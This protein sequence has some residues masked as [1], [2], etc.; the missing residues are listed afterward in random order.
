MRSTKMSSNMNVVLIVLV[1][2]VLVLSI[3]LV[4]HQLPKQAI[5][6]FDNN[7]ISFEC[8]A[9]TDPETSEPVHTYDCKENLTYTCPGT[10]DPITSR[11]SQLECDNAYLKTHSVNLGNS[12]NNNLCNI[13]A[14]LDICVNNKL[15]K[16][17]TNMTRM[18]AL[19]SC[20]K[21]CPNLV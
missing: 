1:V 12:E 4:I 16:N 21:E 14:N 10:L 2:I 15:A 20:S 3:V 9:P 17:P 8:P 11:P 5:E 19:Q 18:N 13:F 6:N 7:F